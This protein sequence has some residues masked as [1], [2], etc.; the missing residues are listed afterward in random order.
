MKS[1]KLR[2]R[3]K[4]R[5]KKAKRTL[6]LK[7]FKGGFYG[8]GF[9]PAQSSGKSAFNFEHMNQDSGLNFEFRQAENLNF[10]E[11]SDRP[12]LMAQ[13]SAQ[14]ESFDESRELTGRLKKN[15]KKTN[16][17]DLTEYIRVVDIPFYNE[18]IKQQSPL[19]AFDTVTRKAIESTFETYAEN[20]SLVADIAR[21]DEYFSQTFISEMFNNCFRFI[22][23]TILEILFYHIG[24]VV[25]RKSGIRFLQPGIDVNDD[26]FTQSGQ[27]TNSIVFKGDPVTG[28]HYVYVDPFNNVHGTYEELILLEKDDGVCHFYALIMALQHNTRGGFYRPEMSFHVFDVTPITFTSFDSLHHLSTVFHQ[29]RRNPFLIITNYYLILGFIRYV[30]VQDVWVEHILIHGSPVNNRAAYD[31]LTEWAINKNIL[32]IMRSLYPHERFRTIQDINPYG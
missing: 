29:E 9:T 13:L 31:L 5:T 12:P 4:S 2:L 15:N 10:V 6:K 3:N 8:F 20:Y 25:V 32:K 1:K 24:G 17:I 21:N 26:T 16:L 14:W 28:G 18:L 30:I 23:L 11:N 7:S 22:N 27:Y 19:D